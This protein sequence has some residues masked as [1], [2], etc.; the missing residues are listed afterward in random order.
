[1]RAKRGRNFATIIYP[2]SDNFVENFKEIIDSWHVPAFLS[3]LHDSDIDGDG[4]IKK[5]HYHLLVK[6]DGNKSEQQVRE[7][8]EQIDGVGLEFVD[9]FRS[10]ARYLCHLDNA[11]DPSKPQYPT[12]DV[13]VFG[14]MDF[15]DTVSVQVDIS[16]M[17]DDIT[18]FVS[19]YNIV[20]FK[21]LV[22]WAR[23]HNREWFRLLTSGYTIYIVNY[24]KSS[25]Y[26]R[27]HKDLFVD[28]P[29]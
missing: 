9:N 28:L 14:G 5:A 8:F 22:D 15:L 4:C 27:S 21:Q 19:T 29:D 7:K 20:L 11:D 3:P 23:G 2:S 18:E 16:E 1:M 25:E 17:L 6:F 26:G 13:T 24:M 10:Y 12:S